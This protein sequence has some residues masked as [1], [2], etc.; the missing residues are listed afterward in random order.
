[1]DSGCSRGPAA[2]ESIEVHIMNP[3]AQWTQASRARPLIIS[4]LW[5]RMI[6]AP[7]EVSSTPGR[8][9]KLSR[10]REEAES[11]SGPVSL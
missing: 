10:R 3:L 2:R 9:P 8:R 7:A 4:R 1:M 5:T 6:I 11:V